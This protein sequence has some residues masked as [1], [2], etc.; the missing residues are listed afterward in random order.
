MA[1]SVVAGIDA[2]VLLAGYGA[3]TPARTST[4]TLRGEFQIVTGGVEYRTVPDVGYVIVRQGSRRLVNHE[5]SSGNTFKFM[6]PAGSFQVSSARL[7]SP[8]ETQFSES[9][10]VAIRANMDTR[11]EVQC[12]LNPTAG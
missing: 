2:A 8:Q 11:I 3:S 9:K 6:L 7:P 4:G 1:M 10:T 12:L 5:V